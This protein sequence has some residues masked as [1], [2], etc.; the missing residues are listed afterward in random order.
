MFK[1]KRTQD[2]FQAVVDRYLETRQPVASGDVSRLLEGQWSSAT[3]RND[4]ADLE[5]LGL[6]ISPHTS[7]GRIPT[8][9]GL[10]LFVDE[11]IMGIPSPDDTIRKHIEGLKDVRHASMETLFEQATQIVSGLSRYAA[12]VAA[13]KVNRTVSSIQFVRLVDGQ[14]MA[15]IVFTDGSAENRMVSLPAGLSMP[16]L[17]Q[18][19]NYLNARLSGKTITDMR[20]SILDEITGHKT[21][22]DAM[23]EKLVQEGLII[24]DEKAEKFLIR[25]SANL[26]DA[27]AEG[28]IEDLKNLM[29]TL[30][31]Q[32]TVERILTAADDGQGV[33]VFIG[34]ENR[35]FPH[36]DMSVVTAQARGADQRLLGTI[37]VI[38]PRYMNYRQIVPLVDQTAQVMSQVMARLI[39]T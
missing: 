39:G 10:R 26:L 28:K 2:I 23:A 3:I 34:T 11:M 37:G 12:I 6:I 13:P 30:E 22:L 35:L 16:V 36:T 32:E 18:A 17:E 19:T 27:E 20:Q 5:S 7:A 8:Q 38:G 21:Q 24:S 14:T 4:M 31:R 1:S 33:R 15:I 25:G 29:S 9:T